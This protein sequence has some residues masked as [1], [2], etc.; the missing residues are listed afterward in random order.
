MHT[1]PIREFSCVSSRRSM[2][3]YWVSISKNLWL[4]AHR[5]LIPD[6]KKAPTTLCSGVHL[7]KE[8]KSGNS[9]DYHLAGRAG[10]LNVH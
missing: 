5:K 7:L 2:V 4:K 8:V 9:R 3:D 1:R 10:I 6:L